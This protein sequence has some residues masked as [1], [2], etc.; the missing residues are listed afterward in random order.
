MSNYQ[1]HHLEARFMQKSHDVVERARRGDP[2]AFRQLVEQHEGLVRST[3]AGMLGD[4]AEADDVAQEVFI[5]FY[6]A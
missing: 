2:T 4:T 1:N 5:R 6:K 3:V